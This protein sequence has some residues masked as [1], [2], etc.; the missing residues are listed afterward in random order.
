[1]RRHCHE[2][3][4]AENTVGIVQEVGAGTTAVGCV[5]VGS[6]EPVEMTVLQVLRGCEL[7]LW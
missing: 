6:L 7:V 2:L 3:N 4:L 5:S 1:M